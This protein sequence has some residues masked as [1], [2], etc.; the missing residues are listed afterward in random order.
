MKSVAGRK[1][2]CWAVEQLTYDMLSGS[3]TERVPNGEWCCLFRLLMSETF[4]EFEPGINRQG[5]KICFCP[6]CGEKICDWC[7]T[8]I[9]RPEPL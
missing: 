2:K 6:A 3:P 7:E 5:A 4:K 8:S 1:C 9:P